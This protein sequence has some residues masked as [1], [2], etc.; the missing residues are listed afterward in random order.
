MAT[1]ATVR[2]E[3]KSQDERQAVLFV[4]AYCGLQLRVSVQSD[5]ELQLVASDGQIF[6]TYTSICRYLASIS[7]KSLQLLGATALDR[8][9]VC[10]CHGMCCTLYAQN[11]S[12]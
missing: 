4:A 9:S 8:A 12:L 7:P 6:R 3:A 1:Q 10:L 11:L 2:I 5:T